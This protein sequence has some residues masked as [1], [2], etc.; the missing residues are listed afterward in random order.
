MVWFEFSGPRH[1]TTRETRPAPK[2]GH[3][4][5]SLIRIFPSGYYVLRAL[6]LWT[7]YTRFQP[8]GSTSDRGKSQG[9]PRCPPTTTKRACCAAV[10]TAV[11]TTFK[12]S[13]SAAPDSGFPSWRMYPLHTYVLKWGFREQICR[14]R[15]VR[16]G[17][18]SRSR[19][20]MYRISHIASLSEVGLWLLS[21][22]HSVP[23]PTHVYS[24]TRLR[25]CV[26]LRCKDV[27]DGIWCLRI[28]RDR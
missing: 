26:W 16:A 9:W 12:T 15:A 21:P 3:T 28:P 13:C 14:Y 2:Q 1:R 6:C 10:S 23:R 8:R 18:Q 20:G 11:Y 17:Q 4:N 27:P 25:Y 19:V 22:L 5:S 24:Y 7:G